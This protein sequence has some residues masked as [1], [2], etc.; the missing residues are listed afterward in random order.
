MVLDGPVDFVRS[1]VSASWLGLGGGAL[2]LGLV[3]TVLAYAIWADLL[4]RYPAATVT[5]FALLA[6]L[7]G[8][9]AS[10]LVFGEQFGP[11][12][13]IGMALV[14]L[15]LAIIMLPGRRAPM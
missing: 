10:R 3:A 13:L 6:P 12:R 4:R 7:V 11:L 1:A 15:G 8:A 5:P 14:L 9:L 2:Y